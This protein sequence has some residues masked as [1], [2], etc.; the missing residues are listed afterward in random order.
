[1]GKKMKAH[2][3]RTQWEYGYA[4]DLDCRRRT[5]VMMGNDQVRYY[6]TERVI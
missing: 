4:D 6:C 3:S 1:M 2:L 5:C